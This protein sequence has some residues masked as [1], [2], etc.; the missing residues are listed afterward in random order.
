MINIE[1]KRVLFCDLDGTL[2]KTVSKAV[3]PKDVT[4]FQ[5]RKDVLDKVKDLGCFTHLA[6]VTNQ[7]GIPKFVNKEDF[8]LRR[9][10]YREVL[11]RKR[12]SGVVLFV[13]HQPPVSQAEPRHAGGLVRRVLQPYE[14]VDDDDDRRRFW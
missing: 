14:Q 12:Q 1:N 13:R 7:A 10:I 6:I 3:F 5:I 4:D 2:I 9:Q 8:V 11:F